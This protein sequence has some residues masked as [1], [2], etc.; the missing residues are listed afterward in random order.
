MI[1]PSKEDIKMAIWA[2][3]DRQLL[4]DEYSIKEWENFN[5]VI[6]FL[7]QELKK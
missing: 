3:E 1:K 7:E 4:C 6:K 2:L 5:N